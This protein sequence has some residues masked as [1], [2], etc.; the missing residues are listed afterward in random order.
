MKKVYDMGV[1]V[2]VE[3]LDKVHGKSRLDSF[4]RKNGSVYIERSSIIRDY[5]MRR[6]YNKYVFANREAFSDY[7]VIWK[8]EDGECHNLSDE[9]THYINSTITAG[10][11]AELTEL[12]SEM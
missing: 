11:M 1:T 2:F 8:D 4:K 12:E 6:V 10:N 5:E 3:F 7:A 9:F